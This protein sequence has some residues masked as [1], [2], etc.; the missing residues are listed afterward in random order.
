VNQGEPIMK[1]RRLI[2]QLLAAAFSLI[3]LA[4]CADS[5]HRFPLTAK[6]DVRPAN[7]RIVL[8][9]EITE[10]RNYCI[11]VRFDGPLDIT[12]LRKFT[13]DLSFQVVTKDPIPAVIMPKTNEELHREEELI[14]QGVYIRRYVNLGVVMPVHVKIEK[15]N[16]DNATTAILLDKVID[17]DR[18]SYIA[19]TRK[20]VDIALKP[21][22]YRV[23]LDTLKETTLPQGLESS[24]V[25]TSHPN[26]G[27]LTN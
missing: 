25:I 22:K 12:E 15:L 5:F 7:S 10:Y 13:G 8:D 27:L 18:G 1:S 6:W 19:L 9:A 17:T 23:E 14:R 21:G 4:A 2:A 20:I 26:S 3:P 24:V 16:D 11:F